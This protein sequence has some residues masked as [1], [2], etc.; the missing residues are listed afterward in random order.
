MAANATFNMSRVRHDRHF[1]GTVPL[2]MDYSDEQLRQW[3]CFGRE[4]I[5]YLAN[6]LR[7]NLE[8]ATAKR[9][10]LSTEQQIMIALRFYASG[11]QL[12]VVGDTL[13]FDKST[14]SRVVDSVTDALVARKDQHIKWPTEIQKLNT[15]KEAFIRRHTFQILLVVLMVLMYES[16][17]RQKMNPAIGIEKGITASTCRVFV[18]IMVCIVAN[19]SM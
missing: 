6:E 9:T 15:I 5:D 17:H 11:A 19:Y 14:V 18:M 1:R 3:F 10:A 7:G 16:R 12:Q 8:R 2:T 13:G 4:T